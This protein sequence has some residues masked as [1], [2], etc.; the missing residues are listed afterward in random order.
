MFESFD[1][2][3]SILKIATGVIDTLSVRRENM[4]NGLSSDLLAT[5]LAYYLVRKGVIRIFN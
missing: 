3:Y 2:V 5:D 1:I 4:F